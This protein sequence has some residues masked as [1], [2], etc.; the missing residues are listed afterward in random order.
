METL[1][2]KAYFGITQWEKSPKKQFVGVY[3]WQY[4]TVFRVPNLQK[5]TPSDCFFWWFCPLGL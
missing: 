4:G 2:W 1:L 3:L 5:H